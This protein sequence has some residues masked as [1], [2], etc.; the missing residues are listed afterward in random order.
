MGAGPYLERL[1]I[2]EPVFGYNLNRIIDGLTANR[3]QGAVAIVQSFMESAV[4]TL[5]ANVSSTFSVIIPP[6]QTDTIIKTYINFTTPSGAGITLAID[7]TDRT[8][9]LGGPWGSGNITGIDATSFITTTGWH[10]LTFQSTAG[11]SITIHFQL[12]SLFNDSL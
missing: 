5:T 4:L 10:N 9:A 3:S 7:G 12:Q 1:D 8:V 6:T 2:F 11:T